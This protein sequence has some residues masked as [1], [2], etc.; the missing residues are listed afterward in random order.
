MKPNLEDILP[1]K[2]D[3]DPGIDYLSQCLEHVN[4][5][6][7]IPGYITIEDFKKIIQANMHIPAKGKIGKKALDVPFYYCQAGDLRDLDLIPNKK[8]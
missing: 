4:F 2:G 7:D 6:M 1:I 5:R 3:A 8:K